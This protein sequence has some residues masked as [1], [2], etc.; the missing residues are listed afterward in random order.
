M[1]CF[2]LLEWFEANF[3]EPFQ[4]SVVQEIKIIQYEIF[5]SIFDNHFSSI[6]F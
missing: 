1:K 2:F 5:S 3:I 6:N 4:F